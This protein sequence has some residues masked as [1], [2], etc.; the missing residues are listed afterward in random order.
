MIATIN[1]GRSCPR[2]PLPVRLFVQQLKNDKSRGESSAV[3]GF[4]RGGLVLRRQ[5][6]VSVLPAL[7]RG[8]VRRPGA[9]CGE[10]LGDAQLVTRAHD[11]WNGGT[12][13]RT[14]AILD[15]I[16]YKIREATPVGGTPF[17]VRRSSGLAGLTLPVTTSPRNRV[18]QRARRSPPGNDSKMD[19]L[20]A[21]G[22]Q[23]I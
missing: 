3:H 13:D 16:P 9:G 1:G 6:C 8:R 19:R 4:A 10:L 7:Q 20:S 18:S 5:I 21:R 2:S 11:R 14:L 12:S 22:A 17:S 23:V 15:G